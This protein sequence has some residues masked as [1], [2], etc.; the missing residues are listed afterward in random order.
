MSNAEKDGIKTPIDYRDFKKTWERVESLFLK[1]GQVERIRI[2]D[3]NSDLSKVRDLFILG[4][5]T[6]LRF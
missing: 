4:C 5:Y 6:G 1:E 2:V 3:L